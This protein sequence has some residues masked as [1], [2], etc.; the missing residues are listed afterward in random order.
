[1]EFGVEILFA[2]W[3]INAFKNNLKITHLKN[4]I[5]LALIIISSISVQS[6][7]DL[8]RH[9]DR[10]EIIKFVDGK[11]EFYKVYGRNCKMIYSYKKKSFDFKCTADWNSMPVYQFF[12]YIETKNGKVFVSLFKDKSNLYQVNDMLYTKNTIEFTQTYLLESG[13]KVLEIHRYRN[14]N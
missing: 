6:Q 1:L 11:K 14:I 9:F 13:E 10:H 8:I 3:R 4:Y 5:L 2:L 12:D 7:N